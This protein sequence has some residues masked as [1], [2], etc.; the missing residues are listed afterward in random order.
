MDT[1]FPSEPDR[2]RLH[3][4][5]R[6]DPSSGRECS[7][8]QSNL[9]AGNDRWNWHAYDYGFRRV[10][11]DVYDRSSPLDPLGE[12]FNAA[13]ADAAE[14]FLRARFGKPKA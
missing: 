8:R 10:V 7:L 6:T 14:A 2:Q 13:L 4:I 5:C 1:Q 12:W 9:G 11:W 3:R